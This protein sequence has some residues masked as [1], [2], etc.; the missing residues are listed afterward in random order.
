MRP[1]V[2]VHVFVST[3]LIREF[4]STLSELPHPLTNGEG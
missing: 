4:L 3:N 1:S 2:G